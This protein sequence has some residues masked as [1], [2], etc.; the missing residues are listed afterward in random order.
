MYRGP[1][2]SRRPCVEAKGIG[3]TGFFPPHHEWDGRRSNGVGQT[4]LSAYPARRLSREPLHCCPHYWPVR[5]GRGRRCCAFNI[6][7]MGNKRGTQ[8]GLP[9]STPARSLGRLPCLSPAGGG[10]RLWFHDV[11]SRVLCGKSRRPGPRQSLRLRMV[12]QCGAPSKKNV[13]LPRPPPVASTCAG[14]STV[15]QSAETEPTLKKRE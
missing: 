5:N 9:Y 1:I 4:R 11:G 6:S 13:V 7:K 3:D 14:T 12:S 10:P 8:Q 2:V 15:A